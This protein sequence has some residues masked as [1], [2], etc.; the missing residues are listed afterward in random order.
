[1]ILKVKDTLSALQKLAQYYRSKFNDIYIIGI[2]GS[3]G[4]TTCKELTAAVL[5]KK[6]PT[7]MNKGNLNSEIGLPLSV[8]SIRDYHR[9]GVFE[10]G[11]NRAGEMDILI[12]VLKPE[13]GIIT[14]IGT[15]HIGML[16]SQDK[17]AEEKTKIF[18]NNNSFKSGLMYAKDSYAENVAS[19]TQNKV[20]LYDA[21]HLTGLKSIEDCGINGSIFHFDKGD[22]SLNLI[23]FYNVQNAAAAIK[24][25]EK[26]S[27][28]F[29]L[30]KEGIESVRALFGRGEI[31]NGAVTLISE[32]Y[33][34]NKE[35][36]LSAVDFIDELDWKG[37]KTV[38]I[39]SVLEL[40]DQSEDIH[41]EI[42]RRIAGSKLML[43][44]LR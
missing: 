16:G 24:T 38:L 2:T 26:L 18:L 22:I 41:S 29:R 12:D 1:M 27:V 7:V 21:E 25:A 3:S 17:I 43:L 35:A 40:G 33:N 30:I 44:F 6:A 19:L 11:M 42:G 8:F 39:G 13:F 15:A 4:K 31:Y 34:S 37:R 10:M 20:K 14:N 5:S 36:V 9:Y 23:G 32:C 28:D